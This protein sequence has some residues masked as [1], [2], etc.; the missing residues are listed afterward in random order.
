MGTEGEEEG[1]GNTCVV[2]LGFL[3]GVVFWLCF[4]LT[5]CCCS[6]GKIFKLHSYPE[7]SEDLGAKQIFSARTVLE[8]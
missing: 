6:V 7:V 3:L 2:G 8:Q 4:T 1:M 5:S